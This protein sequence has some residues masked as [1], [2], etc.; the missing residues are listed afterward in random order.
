VPAE[1]LAG[2]CDVSALSGEGTYT[3]DV[4][5][6]GQGLHISVPSYGVN[7]LDAAHMPEDVVLQQQSVSTRKGR[8]VVAT[9]STLSVP[10]K[11]C[12]RTRANWAWSTHTFT[13]M[14]ISSIV[15]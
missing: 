7:D 1:P 9:R 4:T 8:L 13:D 12:H 2:A 3:D 11:S 5:T 15:V 6:E 14:V 10:D